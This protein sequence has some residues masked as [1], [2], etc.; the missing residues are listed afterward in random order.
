MSCC[1]LA[2]AFPN[3][4]FPHKPQCCPTAQHATQSQEADVSTGNSSLCW[5][6]GVQLWTQLW[7]NPRT[8]TFFAAQGEQ[9]I[10]GDISQWTD[11]YSIVSGRSPFRILKLPLAIST[12][13]SLASHG[14]STEMVPEKVHAFPFARKLL[15][16]PWIR[17]NL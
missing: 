5:Q 6:F 3:S 1:T 2:R 8:G 16:F 7:R 9:R 10:S 12:V 17:R 14:G 11:G 4:S 15:S 13:C